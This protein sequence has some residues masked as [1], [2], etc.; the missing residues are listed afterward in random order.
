MAFISAIILLEVSLRNYFTVRQNDVNV[1][2]HRMSLRPIINTII[3]IQEI[4][5]REQNHIYRW[6]D[7]RNQILHYNE[8]ITTRKH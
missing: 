4:L 3:K 1:R 5:P 7:T 6:I 8:E 2:A